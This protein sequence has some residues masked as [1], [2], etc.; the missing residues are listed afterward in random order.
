M[1]Y[2]DLKTQFISISHGLHHTKGKQE[3]NKN[4]KKCNIKKHW[5]K[6]QLNVLRQFLF[7]EPDVPVSVLG[8][9]KRDTVKYIP[10][11]EGVPGG[12]RGCPRELWKAKGYILLLQASAVERESVCQM[13]DELRPQGEEQTQSWQLLTPGN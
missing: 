2:S 3:L 13:Q 1:I 10:L 11:P 4:M 9:D 12:G 5:Y 7:I 8:R 6:G